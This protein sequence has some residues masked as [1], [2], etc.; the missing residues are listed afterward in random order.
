MASSEKRQLEELLKPC[1]KELGFRKRGGTWHRSVDD[2]I[3]VVNLQSSQWSKV[4]FVNLG[5]YF[6]AIGSK[7]RPAEYSCHVRTRLSQLV[8][9][10]RRLA[11]LLDLHSKDFVQEEGA[12]FVGLLLHYGV[13]WLEQCS[14]RDGLLAA[15]DA[16]KKPIIHVDAQKL[17][18]F[19]Q[20][21]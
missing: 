4:F 5:V 2:V 9:D 6:T 19:G 1:L 18:G 14:K 3:H 15:A 17:F 8:P 21:K 10:L 13:P 11:Y 16:N 7:E 12:E 20:S